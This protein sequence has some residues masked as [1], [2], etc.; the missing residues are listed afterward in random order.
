MATEHC[1]T[2]TGVTGKGASSMTIDYKAIG[3]KIQHFRTL[4]G[5][6][7]ESLAEAAS[8]SRVHLSNL[9]R[10]EKG[11]TLETFVAILEALKISPDEILSDILTDD[12]PS[13]YAACAK[14]L[15]GCSKAESDFLL[16]LLQN[17]KQLLSKFKLSK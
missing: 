12:Q 1:E 6:S 10:G 8:V 15:E 5:V 14:I 2:S 13:L 17:A 16:A 4:Q 7:Q 11:T 9:E 3:A